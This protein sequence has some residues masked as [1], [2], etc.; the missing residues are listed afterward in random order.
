MAAKAD[1]D[2]TTWLARL[3]W[4]VDGS[5]GPDLPSG[6]APDG[7]VRLPNLTA[8]FEHE[9]RLILANR[10]NSQN[11]NPLIYEC[12]FAKAQVRW[13]KFLDGMERHL[14]CIRGT[15]RCLLTS[16]T[17]VARQIRRRSPQPMSP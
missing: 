7:T 2:K 13:M 3:L 17:T 9:V 16:L 12:D 6:D 10:L 8:R 14:P 11:P 15:A 4:L 5:A 1:G